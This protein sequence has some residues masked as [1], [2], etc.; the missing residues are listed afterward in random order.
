M[1]RYSLSYLVEGERISHEHDRLSAD[2]IAAIAG[3][4]VL[5]APYVSGPGFVAR[6][7]YAGKAKVWHVRLNFAEH[8]LARYEE[9]KAFKMR[10]IRYAG[11]W[12]A[13]RTAFKRF[14][15]SLEASK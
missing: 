6:L 7:G 13:S 3:W 9:M 12:R 11:A 8:T 14:L 4:S 15:T 10:Y 5:S 2:G 1:T